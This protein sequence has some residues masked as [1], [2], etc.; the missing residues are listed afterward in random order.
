[1]NFEEF[2]KKEDDFEKIIEFLFEEF[3]DFSISLVK[4]CFELLDVLDK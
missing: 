4:C 2:I 1:M 3:E